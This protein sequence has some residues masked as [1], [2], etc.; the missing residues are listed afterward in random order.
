MAEPVIQCPKCGEQIA[1]SESLAAPLLQRQRKVVEAEAAEKARADIAL[2]QQRQQAQL[3]EQEKLLVQRTAELAEAQK[4]QAE[5]VRRQRELDDEKRKLD[6]TIEQRVSAEA[7]RLREQAQLQADERNRLKL[8][9]KDQQ[10]AAVKLQLE[11]AQRKAEQGSQQMQGEVLELALEAQLRAAFPHDEILPVPKGEHGGDVLQRVRLAGGF[12]CGSI[13]WEAKRTKNWSAGW[14]AKLRE[15]QRAA[16]AEVAILM[17][18]ALPPEVATAAEIEGIWVTAEKHALLLATVQRGLLMQL[19]ALRQSFEGQETKMAMVYQ[20]LTTAQFRN[21]IGAVVER[22]GD[23][24]ADLARERKQTE[25]AWAKRQMQIDGL[26]R[27]TAGLFGDLQGI[28]GQSL[29]DLP[30]LALD[31]G[32]P[33]ALAAGESA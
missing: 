11:A 14:L 18:Q 29:A 22:V 3:R 8:E 1:L 15:D 21:R 4:A 24:Q 5:F 6:L 27:A 31:G 19:A 10:L 2:E 12:H 30:A 13:L 25:K 9:E 17:S 33:A 16:G 20:Y 23:M 32:D 26:V 7:G 28:L